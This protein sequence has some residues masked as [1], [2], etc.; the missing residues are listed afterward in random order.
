MAI[1]NISVDTNSR[2]AVLT[3]DNQ[4]VPAVACHLSKGVDFDGIPFLDLRYVV[5][6]QDANGLTERREFFLPREDDDAV[7]AA[8]NGLA[9][10]V[11]KD[12]NHSQAALDVIKYM[13]DRK[14]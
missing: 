11:A 12:D 3:V 6:V 5:E 4:I 14:K 10:R 13:N 7:F 8:E 9:S 1:V 2:Q